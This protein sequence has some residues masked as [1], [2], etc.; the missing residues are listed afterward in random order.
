MISPTDNEKE[1]EWIGLN[2]T[3]QGY[4]IVKGILIITFIIL[5][6]FVPFIFELSLPTFVAVLVILLAISYGLIVLWSVLFYHRY[7]YSIRDDGVYINRGIWFKSNRTIPY[8]RVQH[9]A[10]TRG[11]LEIIFG[12]HDINIFTAGTSSMG[13]SA[14]SRGMFGAEGF[15]PGLKDPE[16]LRGD[17]WER[18]KFSKSGSGLG[19]EVS[20]PT[21]YRPPV[22]GTDTAILE[23]LRMIRGLLERVVEKGETE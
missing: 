17:I 2:P 5:V 1:G 14:A 8:E 11:P 23:E 9:I 22:S 4:W 19:D 12:I 7:I 20:P 21:T 10:V 13:S 6:S 16:P 15:I 18:V 3:V